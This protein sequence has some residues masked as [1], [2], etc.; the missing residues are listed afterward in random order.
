ME[1]KIRKNFS[2]APRRRRKETNTREEVTENMTVRE[3]KAALL[4]FAHMGAV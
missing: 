1:K 2:L 4:G 3:F